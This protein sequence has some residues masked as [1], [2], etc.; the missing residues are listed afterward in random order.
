[1]AIELKMKEYIPAEIKAAVVIVHGMCEHQLR[2]EEFAQ[3]LCNQGYYVMTYDQLGHGESAEGEFGYF[4]KK[5][6]KRIVL[7]VDKAV[8]RVKELYPDLPVFLFAHSM[9]AIVARCY[10]QSHDGDID[11]LILS[12]AP[13]H[14]KST[15]AARGLAKTLCAVRGP[16]K[17][18]DL[19]HMLAEGSYSK[20]IEGAETPLDWL[21]FNK[22]NIEK[23]AED[24]YCQIRFTN[25][26]YADLAQGVDKMHQVR[27]YQVNKPD[28]PILFVAGEQDPCI[29]GKEGF[30]Q[31]MDRL[32][33]AGYTD[34]S[35]HLFENSRHEILNDNEKEE[36]MAYVLA[37]MEKKLSVE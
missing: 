4:G 29:G 35:S 2:Y 18:T 9:G 33:K 19:L 21:S 7:C 12:G 22:E 23:Y 5:G 13:N 27:K 16:K 8:K 24:P 10:I 1:M 20:S 26:A 32:A 25:R 34:I 15:K 30:A 17:R 14:P 11:G 28:L 6:W 3:Y 36:V 37:W 31:S